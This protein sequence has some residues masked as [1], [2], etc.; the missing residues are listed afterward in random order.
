L[1]LGE[2]P[3]AFGLGVVLVGGD[4]LAAEGF[5]VFTGLEGLLVPLV[6]G[7]LECLGCGFG[8]IQTWGLLGPWGSHHLFEDHSWR[9]MTQCPA[10][11]YTIYEVNTKQN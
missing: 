4:F 11:P 5:K 2:A 6:L 9:S 8:S 7:G 1:E 3:A 10:E